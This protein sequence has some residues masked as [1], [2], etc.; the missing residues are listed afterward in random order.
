MTTEICIKN[1]L[2]VELAD[3]ELDSRLGWPQ[4]SQGTTCLY[5][6]LNTSIKDCTTMSNP[7]FKLDIYFIIIFCMGQNLTTEPQLAWNLW[8]KP[9]WPQPGELQHLILLK[10][11]F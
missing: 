2:W 5:R 6:L 9:G 4:N 3:L 8:Y 1:F 10:T 7:S 11:N